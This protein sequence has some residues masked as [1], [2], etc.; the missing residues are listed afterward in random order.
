MAFSGVGE[1]LPREGNLHIC[2]FAEMGKLT[3]PTFPELTELEGTFFSL[4]EKG[5]N[6]LEE[7]RILRA[8]NVT[9]TLVCAGD[10]EMMVEVAEDW[11]CRFH[12]LARRRI[13]FSSEFR[14]DF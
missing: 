5:P 8:G 9:F 12:V 6:I 11:F 1:E 13:P 3:L 14:G 4:R 2:E 7:D 10:D